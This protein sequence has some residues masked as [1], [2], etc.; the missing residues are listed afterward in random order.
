MLQQ[1]LQ[2]FARPWNQLRAVRV[3]RD[4]T[5]LT[6]T[7]ALW[8]S[9]V[10]ALDSSEYFLLLASPQSAQSQWVNQ[11]VRHWLSQPRA[12]RLLIVLTEGEIAWDQQAG[13]LDTER[14]NALP[15]ALR[16]FTEE[17]LWLDLRWARHSDQVSLQNPVFREVVADLS[18]VLRGIPKDQLIGEDVR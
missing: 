2:Q 8:N 10:S 18:S 7:P 1:G 11:E 16:Q 15:E 17:P 6:A 3:F 13:R 14:T 4:K 5:G 9:I 12:E